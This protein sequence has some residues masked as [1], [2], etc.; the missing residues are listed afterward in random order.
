MQFDVQSPFASLSSY[1]YS[2]QSSASQSSAGLGQLGQQFNMSTTAKNQPLN[3]GLSQNVNAMRRGQ[4]T[5]DAQKHFAPL[6]QQLSD[7]T[8][9][10]QWANSVN[11]ANNQSGLQGL[12]RLMQQSLS[13][14]QQ[15]MQN[16]QLLSRLFGGD[17]FGF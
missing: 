8:A 2:P 4:G 17:I 7:Q 10:A 9:N 3:R 14:Q 11:Q 13:N 6:Q 16:Q 15:G 5:Y 12:S 1:I